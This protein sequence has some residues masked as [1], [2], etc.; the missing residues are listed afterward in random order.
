MSQKSYKHKRRD[1]FLTHMGEHKEIKWDKWRFIQQHL[2][3]YIY[4]FSVYLLIY[5][6]LLPFIN[7]FLFHVQLCNICFV[8]TFYFYLFC[9][10]LLIF[11]YLFALY[12]FVQCSLL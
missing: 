4:L 5:I 6:R 3:F 1:G 7:L 9:L 11:I 10:L 8:F 12:L 2:R